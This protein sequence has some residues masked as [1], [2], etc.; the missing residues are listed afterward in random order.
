MR[1]AYAAIGF[2]KNLQNTQVTKDETKFKPALKKSDY[3]PAKSF[4]CYWIVGGANDHKGRL[5]LIENNG[6]FYTKF[7][8]NCSYS[9]T[10][11]FWDRPSAESFLTKMQQSGYAGFKIIE[12]PYW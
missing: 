8:E 1:F 7:G 12:N 9:E 11:C 4:K 2:M 10:K 6:E 3:K 5:Y